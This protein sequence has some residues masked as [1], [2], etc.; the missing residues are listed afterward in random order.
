MGGGEVSGKTRPTEVRHMKGITSHRD[1]VVWQKAMDLAVDVHKI[2]AGLPSTERYGLTAQPARAAS[3]VP[4]NIA[5]G[6]ARGSAKEYSRFLAIAKGSAMETE[7]FL[8]L[9][10]RLGYLNEARAQFALALIVEISKML[11]AMR[12]KLDL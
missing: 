6:S 1:L 9:A 2:A 12:A 11:T 10:T 4:A 5:E 8:V 7:T 3:S